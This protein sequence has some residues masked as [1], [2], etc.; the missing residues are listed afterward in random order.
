[1]IVGHHGGVEGGVQGGGPQDPRVV[2]ARQRT[3]ENRCQV[4][5]S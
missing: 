1:M 4:Q 2:G 5:L 3:G